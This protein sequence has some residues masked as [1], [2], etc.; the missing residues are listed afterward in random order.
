MEENETSRPSA[1][2]LAA[3]VLAVGAM[4]WVG[5]GCADVAQ[6]RA[7]AY[8]GD[9]PESVARAA[10]AA[11]EEKSEADLKRLLLTREEHRELLWPQ[12]PERNTFP[13][14]YIRELTMRDTRK[15]I[16]RAL[17]VWGGTDF[18]FLRLEFTEE[19]EVYEDF[20]VHTGARVW[21]RRPSD[22]KEG[23]IE[24]LDGLVEWNGRWKAFNYRD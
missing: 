11:L 5:T 17:R 13:F 16:D 19:P 21:V 20:T 6:A 24:F 4:A 15:A 8:A 18:E 7:M 22:G 1:W 23:Y 2:L 10:L 9:S 14:E 12:L 3:T